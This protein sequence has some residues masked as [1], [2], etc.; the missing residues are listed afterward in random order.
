MLRKGNGA[1]RV[2]GTWIEPSH[3]YLLSY[4][5]DC[6]HQ[7]LTADGKIGEGNP[8]AWAVTK[9]DKYKG[10]V[11]VPAGEFTMG[12][13][14][15]DTDESPQ[16]KV[17][18][19]AFYI[20]RFEVTNSQYAKFKKGYKYD[21]KLVDETVHKEEWMADDKPM[22]N[23]SW[24]E[25][26][27]YC[28]WAGKRLPTEAEWEKAA[29]GT[30]ARKYP[31]GEMHDMSFAEP[32][33]IAETAAWRAGKSPYGA[34]WMAGGAWEWTADWY[35]PYPGNK[36]DSPSYGEKYKV[37]RGASRF[38]DPSMQRCAHRYYLGPN[39]KQ[40]GYPVGF[41]CVILAGGN[42]K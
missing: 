15:G 17:Y 29:R 38:A 1:E 7:L 34:Y 14:V 26:V 31:W 9:P 33:G 11:Y 3:F 16:Q 21:E 40:S 24:H 32:D 19:D 36:T 6:Y 35:Q 27:E 4:W 41:R 13:N 37:I 25:A 39:L 12:S 23:I 20:D 5:K 2:Q 22:V 42:E 28:T 10:M 18:V 30:D 8:P